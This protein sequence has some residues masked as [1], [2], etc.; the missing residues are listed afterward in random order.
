[1]MPL[2]GYQGQPNRPERVQQV[3]QA[4]C[5]LRSES[6]DYIAEIVYKNSVKMLNL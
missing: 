5:E 2:S 4:L 1:D 3:F 6:P